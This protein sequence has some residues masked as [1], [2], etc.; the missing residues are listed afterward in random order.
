MDQP[1]VAAELNELNEPRSLTSPVEEEEQPPLAAL[2]P[3]PHRLVVPYFYLFHNYVFIFKITF[4][5]GG[6]EGCFYFIC[7]VFCLFFVWFSV[8]FPHSR[9]PVGLNASDFGFEIIGLF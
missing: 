3:R 4:I 1:R 8:R 5:W 9:I 6:W 7:W 2:T